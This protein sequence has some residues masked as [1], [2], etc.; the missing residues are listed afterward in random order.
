[1]K[2]LTTIEEI[3]SQTYAWRRKGLTVG[4]VP[5][6]GCLHAGKASLVKASAHRCERTVV[7]ISAPPK[8]YTSE[9][10]AADCAVCESMGA[11]AVYCPVEGSLRPV[12]E[13]AAYVDLPGAELRG[14]KERAQDFC[15]ALTRLFHLVKPDRAFFG[16]KG[17]RRLA[18]LRRLVEE[19]S[20]GIEVVS[21]PI[22][23]DRD[24]LPTASQNRFLS[25]E[26]RKAALC[27]LQAAR[28][29][30][31]MI[32]EGERDARVVVN[33]MRNVLAH[34]PMCK[35]V[36]VEAMDGATLAATEEIRAGVLVTMEIEIGG[37]R[38]SD[39]FIAAVEE[40]QD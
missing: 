20:F 12:R 18:V 17:P 9:D 26:E 11:D 19:L 13:G 23:R 22:V 34:E 4:L 38:L 30:R 28:L 33:A 1:M 27:M 8:G 15:T 21:C 6:R 2:T 24:G 31:R 32:L 39:S 10:F 16:E 35:I 7:S 37:K 5:T 29:G 40:R 36:A 25:K 14:E 3:R